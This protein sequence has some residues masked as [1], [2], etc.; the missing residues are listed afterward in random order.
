M[1][2]PAGTILCS[3]FFSSYGANV[4]HDYFQKAQLFEIWSMRLLAFVS[5]GILFGMIDHVQ[6]E[7]DIKVRLVEAVV[8]ALFLSISLLKQEYP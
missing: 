6:G 2:P 1:F 7:I 3:S 4:T 8:E 5:A